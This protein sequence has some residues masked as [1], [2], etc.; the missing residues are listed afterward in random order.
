MVVPLPFSDI[1]RPDDRYQLV[2]AGKAKAA[3]KTSEL[4][5]LCNNLIVRRGIWAGM[6]ATFPQHQIVKLR[7]LTESSGNAWNR[8]RH[9]CVAL[10]RGVVGFYANCQFDLQ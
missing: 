8:T 9:L 7:Q 6:A 1:C 3:R 2:S 4:R 5:H 10:A